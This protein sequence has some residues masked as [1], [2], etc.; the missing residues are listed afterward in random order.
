M[1]GEWIQGKRIALRL[2]TMEDRR[3]IFEWLAH[4]DISSS[5]F[6][7]PNFP[8]EP[9]PT[10]E[11]FCEDHTPHFFEGEITEQG[12]CFIMQIDNEDVGQIYFNDIDIRN[13]IKR[14]ELDMW[15]RAESYCGNGNGS[16]A[17]MT[18]CEFLANRFGVEKFLVQPSARNPRA[19]RAYEKVGFVR[20]QVPL[21]QAVQEW[22]P[23]DYVDSVYMVKTF[24]LEETQ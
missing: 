4:S 22:G 14:V 16:D 23:N 15:L 6:G 20:L 11:E 19:I 17:L 1:P 10:W 2:S 12:R 5:M 18:L 21:E 8:E 9:P 7:E 24:S 3:P 13:G